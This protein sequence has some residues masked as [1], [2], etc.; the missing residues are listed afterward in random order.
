MKK[1]LTANQAR[2][3]PDIYLTRHDHD[4]LTRLVGDRGDQGVAVRLRQELDRAV[5]VEET[6]L[7]LGA[8]GLNHWLHYTDGK[9][10]SPRRVQIVLPI[11]A[12]IDEGRISVLSHVGA[13]LIGLIEGHSIPWSDPAGT[14]RLL[15]PVLVE[16][17]DLLPG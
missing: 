13:G 10:A 17:R 14:E 12:D 2:A 15:T 11:D 5:I 1:R 6:D 8:V 16:D 7:P 9:A 3:V 4:A